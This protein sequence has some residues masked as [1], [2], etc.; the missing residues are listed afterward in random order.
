MS[1]K[2]TP[3]FVMEVIEENRYLN[4]ATTDGEE[5]WVAPVEF[6]VDDQ[7]NFYFASKTSSRHIN[8]IEQNPVVGFAIYDSQ[9]PS[10][11]GR[12]IQIKG[13]VEK[14]SDERNPFVIFDGRSDLPEKLTD[15]DPDYSAYRIQPQSV[16]VP[17]NDERIEVDMGLEIDHGRSSTNR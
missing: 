8:H 2:A 11:T 15:I 10:M 4:L 12:G 7:L 1:E 5:P 6:V 9:Q 3:E 13:T 14:Y 17:V 16:Y